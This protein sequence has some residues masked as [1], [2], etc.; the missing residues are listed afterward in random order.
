M[1]SVWHNGH[2]LAHSVKRSES[3]Q[4]VSRPYVE[5]YVRQWLNI[6]N[7]LHLCH[8]FEKQTQLADFDRFWHDIHAVKV[9]QYNGLQD[10]I[11]T[12]GMLALII[13][14]LQNLP[15]IGE[16]LRMM[17]FAGPFQFFHKCFHPIQACFV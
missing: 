3:D 10:E 12:F 13:S 17:L 2:S 16:F 5:V 4:R 7:P 6:L 9:M 11:A 8:E 15:K 14:V 1:L